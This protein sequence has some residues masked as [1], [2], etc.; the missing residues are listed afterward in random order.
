MIYLDNFGDESGEAL[1]ADRKFFR[2][3]P[4]R[5]YRVRP[6][7]PGEWESLAARYG[8]AVGDAVPA[9]KQP[10]VAMTRT[11]GGIF[12]IPFIAPP[13]A[14]LS[15]DDEDHASWVFGK[16]V[17]M[18]AKVDPEAAKRAIEPE[19]EGAA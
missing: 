17:D 6:A 1:R 10:A 5:H 8:D 15:I 19:P 13:C 4:G 9:G 16:V 3:H 12:R 11:G 7:L 2:R 18:F 14:D